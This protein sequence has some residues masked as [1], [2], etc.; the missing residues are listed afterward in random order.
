[1][2]EN[3][4]IKNDFRRYTDNSWIEEETTS[5]YAKV[6]IYEGYHVFGESAEG[7]AG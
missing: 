6:T 2:F 1:M 4:L 7:L 5:T 3:R